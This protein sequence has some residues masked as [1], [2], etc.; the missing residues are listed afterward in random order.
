M[1]SLCHAVCAL[2]NVAADAPQLYLLWINP[3][4]AEAQE[5]LENEPALQALSRPSPYSVLGTAIDCP[6]VSPP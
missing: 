3:E 6:A 2:E 1:T 5:A 4:L